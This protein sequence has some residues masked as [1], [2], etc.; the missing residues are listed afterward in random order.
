MEVG[1]ARGTC[2]SGREGGFF[3]HAVFF[4]FV[5]IHLGGEDGKIFLVGIYSH[6]NK[7]SNRR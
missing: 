3:E 2:D 4:D 7:F 6:A 5:N 1:F